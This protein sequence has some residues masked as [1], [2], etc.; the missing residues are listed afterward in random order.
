MWHWGEEL[1]K[2]RIIEML[3]ITYRYW[4]LM[5]PLLMRYETLAKGGNRL[6]L[7]A[8]VAEHGYTDPRW[9]TTRQYP[10]KGYY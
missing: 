6:R 2:A 1:K 9:A 4:N 5:A 3:K 7:M 8:M 10:Q